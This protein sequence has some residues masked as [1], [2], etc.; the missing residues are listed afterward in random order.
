M[1]LFSQKISIS[2]IV[3]NTIDPIGH[4]IV[5][6]SIKAVASVFHFN[7]LD[8]TA[9]RSTIKSNLWPQTKNFTA[10]NLTYEAVKNTVL[11]NLLESFIVVYGAWRVASANYQVALAFVATSIDVLLV[12]ERLFWYGG[13]VSMR[14][15]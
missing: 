4:D 1:A 11:F 9:F 14:S 8:P 2:N 7:G 3:A 6:P 12:L 5:E 15:R 13:P 10:A